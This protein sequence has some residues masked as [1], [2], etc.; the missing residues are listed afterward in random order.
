MLISITAFSQPENMWVIKNKT[1][2]ETLTLNPHFLFSKPIY[3]KGFFYFFKGSYFK[4]CSIDLKLRFGIQ[5][6]NNAV[7]LSI[8]D[9]KNNS[10][11]IIKSIDVNTFGKDAV[12]QFLNDAIIKLNNNR[13]NTSCI[14]NFINYYSEAITSNEEYNINFFTF[15]PTRREKKYLHGD[16]SPK[17]MIS[18]KTKGAGFNFSVFP[19][20]AQDGGTYVLSNPAESIIP[21]GGTLYLPNNFTLLVDPN[22][23]KYISWNFDK[24]IFGDGATIDLSQ[25]NTVY[26]RPTTPPP[27]NSSWFKLD[28]PN[29]TNM[30]IETE[31]GQPS[32][33][34]NGFAGT[35]GANGNNGFDGKNLKLTTRFIGNTGNLWIRTDGSNGQDGQGGGQ[36]GYGARA[37]CGG[38]ILGWGNIDGGNGG[39]GGN[40][41]YGGTGGNEAYAM[42][43]YLDAND[44]PIYVVGNSPPSIPYKC[45]PSIRP[46]IEVGKINISGN[47]GCGGSGGQGG[48]GGERGHGCNC[49]FW[50]DDAHDGHN[51]QTKPNARKGDNGKDFTIQN[52]F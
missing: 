46:V 11:P 44:N 31:Q 40:A 32:Y 28:C 14:D 30:V 25:R 16:F 2:D 17:P 4:Q 38:S 22:T 33:G 47:P 10:I 7:T 52:K 15:T 51:G 18:Q 29:G 9:I 45:T 42:V 36:G 24:V 35:S 5:V 34:G 49:G 43:E 3:K 19:I 13:P 39:D 20:G 12:K 23:I 1:L 6:N 21:D 37:A 8:D 48:K 41:G 27:N 26:T 50:N